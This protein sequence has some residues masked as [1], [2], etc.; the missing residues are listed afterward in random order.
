MN[1]FWSIFLGI[2]QGLTEFLPISSSGHLVL[3][4]SLIPGFSQPGVL[5]YVVLHAGTLLAVIFY[6]R[7]TISKMSARYLA[8]LVVGTIP[9]AIFGFI[10]QSAVEG[11]FQSTR[12]VG[13][14]L[15]ITAAMNYM[16][17]KWVPKT[18]TIGL[19]NAL[20]IGIAQAFAIVPGISRSG[21]TIFAGTKMGVVKKKAAEFSFLLSV[22][23]VLGANI[24]QA[25]TH[26]GNT[27][28][29]L[30]FYI[31]GFVGA[32]VSG[33]IAIGLVFR[34][35]RQRRFTIFAIYCAALGL[36]TIF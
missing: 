3:V 25:L 33:Y 14:A 15:L 35:L 23:A 5:F 10:F 20:V 27:N 7:E 13:I 11:L 18:K 36:L 31:L 30:S 34:L 29:N 6:F 22:P 16:T 24:L 12:L 9:V 1:I 2:L 21:T 19:K 32:A 28:F 26:A 4:Q 17:D 8:L